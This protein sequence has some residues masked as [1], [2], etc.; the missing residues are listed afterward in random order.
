MNLVSRRCKPYKVKVTKVFDKEKIMRRSTDRL[1]NNLITS[2]KYT[3]Y[4]S[5]IT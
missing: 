4:L 2:T 5:L 3:N 1:I